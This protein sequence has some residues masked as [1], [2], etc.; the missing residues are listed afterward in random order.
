MNAGVTWMALPAACAYF[1]NDVLSIISVVGTLALFLAAI[2]RL[3]FQRLTG[4]AQ[5][6]SAPLVFGTLFQAAFIAIGL[7]PETDRMG[8]LVPMP[9]HAISAL[10]ALSMLLL[11]ARVSLRVRRISAGHV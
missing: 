11:A 7:V 6:Y 2:P 8:I 5:W 1:Y 9:P 4:L 10:F 3:P